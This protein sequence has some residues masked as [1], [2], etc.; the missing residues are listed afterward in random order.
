MSKN[1]ED[2]VVKYEEDT[3]SLFRIVKTVLK[4]FVTV[5]TIYLFG[6]F[7]LSVAWL[8]APIILGAFR[9]EWKKVKD[10]K[11]K[12]VQETVL[13]EKKVILST[14]G[15]LPSWVSINV[16]HQY[17]CSCNLPDFMATFGTNSDNP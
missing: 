8:I 17:G 15:D 4:N 1:V 14:L 6:Y 5:S 9:T 3:S 13:N 7:D 2:T 16:L 11:R 12:A 10:R